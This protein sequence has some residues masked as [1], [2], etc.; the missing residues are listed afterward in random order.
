MFA[1]RVTVNDGSIEFSIGFGRMHCYSR[2]DVRA[3]VQRRRYWGTSALQ[4]VLNDGSPG[5]YVL[6]PVRVNR[7]LDLL[8]AAKWP[9]SRSA[10]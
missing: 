7:T 9:V 3:V 4:F 6:N 8:M 1:R 2:G 10:S 5:K